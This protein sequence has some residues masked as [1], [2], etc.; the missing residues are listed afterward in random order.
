MYPSIYLGDIRNA[1][2]DYF[3]TLQMINTFTIKKKNTVNI[4]NVTGKLPP[5]PI[6]NGCKKYVFDD[7][8]KCIA[9]SQKVANKKHDKFL[10]Q[11]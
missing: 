9:S 3:D 6:P 1:M 10:K 11:I 8:F 2:G 5:T 7:G 4:N